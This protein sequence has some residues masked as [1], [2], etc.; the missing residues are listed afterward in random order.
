MT[1][2]SQ[3]RFH[4]NDAIGAPAAEDDGEYLQT[5]FVDTGDLSLLLDNS[6][7]RVIL[8][9]RT[10]SG[11]SALVTRMADDHGDRVIVIRPDELALT[12]ISNSTI[13][14]YFSDL[15]INLDPFYKL[16]WRHVF[17][18]EI[19]TRLFEQKVP[20]STDS[21]WDRLRAVF[22]GPSKEDKEMKEAVDYLESWGKK[23]WNETEFRVKEITSKIESDLE[24]S[25]TATIGSNAAKIGAGG[26]SSIRLSEEQTA[27]VLGRAQRVVASAQVADLTRV[28]KLLGKVLGDEQKSFYIVIDALDEDWVEAKLKYKLIRGLVLTAREFIQIPNAKIVIVLRRDL[29]D[30]V[31]RLTRDAGFQEEKYQGLYLPL[32]W[33]KKDILELL[34]LRVKRMVS[35]RYTKQPVSYKDL[36]PSL[37]GGT[38]IGDYVFQI[39]DRPRDV[40]ALFNICIQLGVDETRL[41]THAFNKAVDQYSRSRLNALADEWAADFPLL[42]DFAEV[43]RNRPPSFKVAT[44][45]SRSLEEICLDTVIAHPDGKGLL[46]EFASS[47]VDNVGSVDAFRETLLQ[48]FYRVGLVGLKTSPDATA[49]WSHDTTLSLVPEQIDLDTSVCVAPKYAVAL[50][51]R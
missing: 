46:F 19:L 8:L 5:C 18:V 15:G 21:L 45:S 17:T 43:L 36:L 39:A 35:R 37:Y 26:K 11:K 12:Y 33:T 14:N 48:V 29:I 34:D 1:D 16:L 49:H 38:Q 30:R 41:S 9:G 22:P 2:T 20:T 13:L 24:N 47:L 23:F 28:G 7:R 6:D 42:L 25:L 50:H 32:E 3:F 10:G 44:M 27:E 31:F 4:K 40:I 51:I